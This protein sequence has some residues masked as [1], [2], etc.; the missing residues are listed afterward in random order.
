M[1]KTCQYCNYEFEATSEDDI[2]CSDN[3]YHLYWGGGYDDRK[4]LEYFFPYEI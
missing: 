1:T 3:C 2:F 4:D